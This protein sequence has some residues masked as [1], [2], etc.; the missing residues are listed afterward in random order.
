MLED[1]VQGEL[2]QFGSKESENERFKHYTTKTY[3]KTA[4][5]IANSC[6][7]IAL[8][9]LENKKNSNSDLVEMSFEFGK[10]LGIAFQLVD[11]ILDFTSHSDNLGKPGSGADLRLGLA[12]AP[13]LF[14]SAKYPQLN[15]MIMR[16]FSD[17]GDCARAFEF[18]MSSDGIEDTRNLAESYCH[19]AEKI[20]NRL[21]PCQEIVYLR[22]IVKSVVNRKN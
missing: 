9:T 13:V 8:L 22:E 2:M 14:A 6:K 12:T 10:N 15:A 18:V 17:E 20:L 5:L 3:R 11:D 16:R 21:K 19:N 1:L 7:A 4:S